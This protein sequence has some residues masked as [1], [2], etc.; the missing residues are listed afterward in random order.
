M[1]KQLAQFAIKAN[2]SS[3]KDICA[4]N[5][6]NHAKPANLILKLVYLVNSAII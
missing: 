2:N 6:L 5:V 4:P 3:K 1:A